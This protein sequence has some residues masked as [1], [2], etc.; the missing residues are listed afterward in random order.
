MPV[1]SIIAPSENRDIQKVSFGQEPLSYQIIM[2]NYLITN[3]KNYKTAKVEFINKPSRLSISH[4][5]NQY[6]GYRVCLSIN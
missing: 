1:P 3:L 5:G 6:S 2:K 4:L